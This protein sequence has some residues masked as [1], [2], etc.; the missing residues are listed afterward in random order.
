MKI[1]IERD[2]TDKG[3]RGHC[4][5]AIRAEET[6]DKVR[7]RFSAVGLT[8]L[9]DITGLDTLGIP[10]FLS[11]RPQAGYL[12]VDG[13]KGFTVAAA[14]AS[15][16]MECFE[17]HAG[18]NNTL[19]NFLSSYGELREDQ[20]IPDHDLPLSRNSLFHPDLAERWT[21]AEDLIGGEKI[22]VPQIMVGLE[23]HRSRRSSLFP[24]AVSSNGLNS[25]NTK[26]EALVGALY[27]VIERDATSCVEYAWGNGFQP[28][29][30][31]LA[32]VAC[33]DAQFLLERI[34]AAGI[35]PVVLDCTVDTRVPTFQ[36]YLCDTK[37]PQIGLYHGYGTHLNPN[38]ALLRALCE[39]AQSRLVYIAG[40][41]DDCFDHHHRVQINTEQANHELL[42]LPSIRSFE[43]FKDESTDTFEADC[44]TIRD[45]LQSIGIHQILTL[46]LTNPSIG[47]DVYRVIVPALEGA[48]LEDY[49]PGNRAVSWL[50]TCRQL[51]SQPPG[52]AG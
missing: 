35:A 2:L 42:S 33:D 21:W 37:N 22:A 32:S 26:S 9:A 49:V 25:G 39:A 48:I 3:L 5:R 51:K 28:A 13:G 47:I 36:A 11:T 24:F 40:S 10:V 14:M 23:R 34:G 45:K 18:E 30:L 44:R 16:A 4:Q 8:R 27:E 41:R 38:V 50:E 31:D 1:L 7:S 19:D 6:L 15:A 20:R 12:S 52:S 29:R 43:T 17:R 46:D